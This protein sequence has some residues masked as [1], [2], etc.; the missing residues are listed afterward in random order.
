MAAATARVPAALTPW[1]DSK[2]RRP[3]AAGAASYYPNA[4]IC[5]NSSG[6][7][8]KASDTAGLRFDGLVA[9]SIRIEVMAADSAGDRTVMVERPWRFTMAIAAAV[10][11]DIG[12]PV[13]V[14]YDNEVAL[15]GTSHSILVGWIDA[16]LSS[17]LVLIRPAYA[18][19][20]G[21]A[22]FDGATLTFSGAS[23]GNTVVMPDNLADA[24]SV[25]E[26]SNSYLTFV[27]TNSGEK[28]VVKKDLEI[29]GAIDL[30]FVG[31]TGQPE[32]KLTDNLA[33]ALS[34]G[35]GANDYIVF[36]TTNS[37]ECVGFKTRLSVGATSE[38]TI[39]SGAITVTGNWHSVDTESDGAS[40]DLDTI[41][42]GVA[43]QVLYLQANNSS[44]TVVVKDGTGNIKCGGDRSLDNAEDVI[45]LISD[46]T[47]WYEVAFASNGT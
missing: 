13:Y 4:M 10:A 1:G 6:N 29:N 33:D 3:L 37:A 17:T 31:T 34:V 38:L 36:T 22:T 23:A 21:V 26:G 30:S 11:G 20:N 12:S 7:A 5:L 2:I 44:R 40:D 14:K 25:K 8:V 46:G 24:L 42:G 16:V 35:E 27:T 18:G 39:A 9:D 45:Q 43:G 41:N 19:V 47:N 15:S 32:I 28:I